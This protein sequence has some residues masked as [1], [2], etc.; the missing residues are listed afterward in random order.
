MKNRVFAILFCLVLTTCVLS[1]TAMADKVIDSGECGDELTWELT[2]NGTLIIS[3]EGD[4]YDFDN[5][6]NF[7][8]DPA[9]W[10]GYRSRIKGVNIKDGVSSIGA[11]AFEECLSAEY[12]SIPDTVTKLG[13]GA[14]S[15]CSITD[16]SVSSS[17]CEIGKWNFCY[18]MDLDYIWVDENNP[19]FSSDDNDVLFNKDKTELICIN[20]RF[21]E[22]T[23]PESVEMIRD[24]AFINAYEVEKVYFT[25]DVPVIKENSFYGLYEVDVHYP[26][27]NPTWTSDVMQDYGGSV[28]WLEYDPDYYLAE[29]EYS[30]LEKDFYVTVPDESKQ[31]DISAENDENNLEEEYEIETDDDSGQVIISILRGLVKGVAAVAALGVVVII[32]YKLFNPN[33]SKKDDNSTKDDVE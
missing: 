18:C 14:I 26:I 5:Y 2:V 25:G 28:E 15:Y 16:I 1:G 17:L 12:I 8:G 19:N 30:F 20:A 27:N 7:G 13:D 10:F 33:K 3:G 24:F 9:P 29:N 6:D 22:Y 11:W 23:V 31:D 4:M 21:D 32:L